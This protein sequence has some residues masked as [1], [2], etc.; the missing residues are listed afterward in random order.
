M[1]RESGQ[2]RCFDTL[3]TFDPMFDPMFDVR[4][5]VRCSIRCSMSTI[6]VASESQT[7]GHLHK[8]SGTRVWAHFYC[9]ALPLK[10]LNQ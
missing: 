3:S 6:D 4:S 9:N 10:R 8:R 5:D 1:E 2:N 7:L